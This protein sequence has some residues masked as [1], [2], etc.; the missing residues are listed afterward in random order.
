VRTGALV[1]SLAILWT[2]GCGYH[3]AGR[4]DRMPR[5][6]QTIAIPAFTNLTTRY[7]LTERL[8]S[9]IA[10]EFITR[11]RYQVVTDPEQADAV[12]RGVI[13][14]YNSYPTVFDPATGR[15]TGVALSVVL[16]LTLT[17]RATGKVL[18]SR[19][20]W[21]AR[22][23]YEIPVDEKAYLDESDAALERLCRQVA[24]AV[25]S[26]ILENF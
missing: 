4:A 24:R 25:V 26:A 22:E 20:H 15:A 18:F 5:H 11:T 8:P 21:E 6:V 10:H 1:A 3:I 13:V 23:R 9:A 12:L 19:P 16:Q 14:S 2:P 17:E 7:R